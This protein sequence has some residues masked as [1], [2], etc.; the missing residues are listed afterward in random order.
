MKPTERYPL[1]H[2]PDRWDWAAIT[3]RFQSQLPADRLVSSTHA[4]AFVG[5]QVTCAGTS[6]RTS[7][8]YRAGRGNPMNPFPTRLP[9]SSSKR[10]VPR[11]DPRTGRT[12]VRQVPATP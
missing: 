6:V 1:L 5:E 12:G 4:V 7:G 11:T 8:S 10:P 9:A 2:L 3:M